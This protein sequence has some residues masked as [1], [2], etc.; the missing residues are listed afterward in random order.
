MEIL[1]KARRFEIK[2]I[3]HVAGPFFLASRKE[4]VPRL[5]SFVT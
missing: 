1:F 3:A 4:V 5:G 2:I